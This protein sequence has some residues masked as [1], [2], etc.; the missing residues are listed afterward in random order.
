MRAHYSRLQLWMDTRA[1]FGNNPHARAVKVEAAS[2]EGKTMKAARGR[3]AKEGDAATKAMKGE[4]KE[5][6]EAVVR[7]FG[8]V[9]CLPEE[10]EE[11]RGW[12]IEE[13]VVEEKEV[14]M[15]EVGD[16]R[17]GEVEVGEGGKH[18]EVVL[19][20]LVEEEVVEEAMGVEYCE[21]VI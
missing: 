3:K 12:S 11:G 10:K 19:E 15:V 6:K 20:E 1:T 5:R 9:Y 14:M 8:P 17:V 18:E 16:V 21:W 2:L 13:M 7:S 4:V